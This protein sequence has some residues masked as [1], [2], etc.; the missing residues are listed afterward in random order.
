MHFDN[1][2]KIAAEN[3][4]ADSHW[5]FWTGRDRFVF[6]GNPKLSIKEDKILLKVQG[7]L[8]KIAIR[9]KNAFIKVGNF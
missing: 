1:S 6:F 2:L 9:E 5:H 4:C 3:I 8:K 7:H